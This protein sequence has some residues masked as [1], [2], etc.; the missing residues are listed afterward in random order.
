MP[1]FMR[2]NEPNAAAKGALPDFERNVFGA[3]NAI[4]DMLD[5]VSSKIDALAARLAAVTADI[6]VTDEPAQTPAPQ[7]VVEPP[8][9][10]APVPPAPAGG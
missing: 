7:P 9:A 5:S 10:P 4:A 3:L 6:G 8:A 1:H 2:D